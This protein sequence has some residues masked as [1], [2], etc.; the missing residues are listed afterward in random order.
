MGANAEQERAG[1]SRYRY[2]V[3]V[4]PVA[5][6]L[7]TRRLCREIRDERRPEGAGLQAEKSAER[8]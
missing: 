5:A 2:A 6:F 3:F 1:S 7:V 8:Q 4:L